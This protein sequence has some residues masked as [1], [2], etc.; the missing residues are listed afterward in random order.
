METREGGGVN[1]PQMGRPEDMGKKERDAGVKGAVERD[2]PDDVSEA[3]CVASGRVNDPRRL[4]GFAYLVMRDV[5]PVGVMGGVMRAWDKQRYNFVIP[6]AVRYEELAVRL[7]GER[8]VWVVV[9][10][11]MLEKLIP[12]DVR[13]K[14]LPALAKKLPEDDDVT[15]VYT[16]GWLAQY[17]IY[18]ADELTGRGH[19]VPVESDGKE[20]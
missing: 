20:A 3:L 5:L 1:E 18:L 13:T 19:G 15:T 17:A 11:A 2:A 14:L 10:L 9:W 6:D 16:N 12:K 4:V 8:G 7:T